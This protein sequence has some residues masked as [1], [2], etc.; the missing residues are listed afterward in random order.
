M[1]TEHS[2]RQAERPTQPVPP[3]LPLYLRNLRSSHRPQPAI[4]PSSFSRRLAS[5]SSPPP[6]FEAL[7]SA[8]A[9]CPSPAAHRSP[10]CRDPRQLC[11]SAITIAPTSKP[12]ATVPSQRIRGQ[13]PVKTAPYPLLLQARVSSHAFPSQ[14]AGIFRDVGLRTHGVGSSSRT[15]T[16]RTP[17]TTQHQQPAAPCSTTNQQQPAITASA[18][19]P[20]YAPSSGGTLKQRARFCQFCVARLRANRCESPIPANRN[21]LR[22][23]PIYR[24]TGRSPSLAPNRPKPP[25]PSFATESAKSVVFPVSRFPAFRRIGQNRRIQLYRQT[26]RFPA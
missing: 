17:T 7:A 21:A 15:G 20:T 22:R 2:L 16:G 5:P 1:T 4:P 11:P 10:N 24:Q 8:P 14:A 25:F 13:H 3:R 26:G 23:S 18:V 6:P 19:P 12:G 9:L